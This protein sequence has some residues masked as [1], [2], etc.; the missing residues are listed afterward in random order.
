MSRD[1]LMLTGCAGTF[2]EDE[3]FEAG[4]LS[5]D[6]EKKALAKGLR[7][8]LTFEKLWAKVDWTFIDNTLP[9]LWIEVLLDYS[10]DV[11]EFDEYYTKLCQV[12]METGTKR[13]V[14]PHKTRIF[15]LKSNGYNETTMTGLLSA[16]KDF[17]AQL[18]MVQLKN[19]LQFQENE[20]ECMEILEPFLEIWHTVWT[21]LSRI[22][23]AHWVGLTSSDPSSI[24]FG[25]NT[26]KRRAPGNVKK[27][28]YYVYMDL[29]DSQVDARVLN[30]WSNEL[31]AKDLFADLGKWSKE[32]KLPSFEV[33][34]EKA[35][36]LH[37]K[38]SMPSAFRSA[39]V[40]G[41]GYKEGSPWKAPKQSK[42]SAAFEKPGTSKKTG[43]EK[44]KQPEVEIKVL[45]DESLARSTRLIY[46][47]MLSKLIN[48]AI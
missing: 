5:L 43:K 6:D 7:A 20:F 18:A 3:S 22:Y 27:V 31:E 16:I 21:N 25:A 19:Y 24:G 4:S 45:G 36:T 8:E 11:P 28:D 30:I 48:H 13:H 42:T 29:L 17:F 1:A 26:L 47:G 41:E 44:K 39:T 23:E 10:K 37:K 2:A 12:F 15:P 40:C 35:K 34:Y 32:G 38:F 33:L 9:F 14:T 46:D